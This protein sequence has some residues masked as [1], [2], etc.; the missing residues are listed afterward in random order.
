MRHMRTLGLGR[1][2]SGLAAAEVLQEQACYLPYSLDGNAMLGPVP[3]VRLGNPELGGVG[4]S[5]RE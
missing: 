5:R 4:Q 1:C 2:A 3:K